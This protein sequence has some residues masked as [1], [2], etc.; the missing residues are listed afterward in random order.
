MIPPEAKATIDALPRDELRIEVEKGNRSRFQRD[1]FA[2]AK[3]RLAELN[4]AEA[5]RHVDREH[6]LME[7]ANRIARDANRRA[8][9]ANWIATA[10]VI[11]AVVS[12]VISIVVWRS[13]AP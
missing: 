10:A 1:N 7:E 2:Y 13:G 3:S 11:V 12:A 9:W 5:A 4:E 6:A 8:T